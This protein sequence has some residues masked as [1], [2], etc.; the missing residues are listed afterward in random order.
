[1]HSQ[2]SAGI[3]IYV[4]K[5]RLE[6]AKTLLSPIK[7]EQMEYGELSGGMQKDEQ[8]IDE[9][10]GYQEKVIW[11]MKRGIRNAALIG[12]GIFIGIGLLLIVI[13]NVLL[14]VLNLF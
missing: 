5:S 10:I 13:Y 6:E 8:S 12:I 14:I 2:S 1:M 3:S 11:R 7:T 9:E 4:D